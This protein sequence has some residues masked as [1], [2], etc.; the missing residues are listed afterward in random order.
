M[1]STSP[2]HVTTMPLRR[3]DTS[4]ERSRRFLRRLVTI[5]ALLNGCVFALAA[6]ALYQSRLRYEERATAAASNVA[7][8]QERDLQSTVDQVNLALLTIADEVQETEAS[9]GRDQDSLEAFIVRQSTRLPALHGLRITNAGG[10]V[11]HGYGLAKGVHANLSDRAYFRELSR[12]PQAGIVISKPLVSRVS[13]E[14]EIV[15]ARRLSRPDGQ[16]D[17]VVYGTIPLK[18]FMDK[19]AAIDLGV[20]GV[21]ALR[22]ADLGMVVR[23]PPIRT[24]AQDV[25]S[26]AIAPKLR[27]SIETGQASGNFTGQAG[28]D[29]VQRA[30]AFRRIGQL[31][32]IIV[33]GL[34]KDDYLADWRAEVS[35]ALALCG[36][37]AGVV[38][39]FSALLHRSWVSRET[40]VNALELQ[41]R[42][43]RTLLESSPD[44]LVIADLQG[45]IA[46][47]NRNA[48]LM[49]GHAAEQ[50][51]GHPIHLLL[52]ARFADFSLVPDV[53]HGEAPEGRHELWAVTS[54][55]RE[56]PVSIS[57]SSINTDQ[58]G[59]VAAAI[60]DMTEHHASA[61]HIEY[62]A[63]HDALTG[64][65]NRATMKPRFAQASADAARSGTH[66]A[67][68]FLDLDGFKTIN[69]SL[70]HGVGDALLKGVAAR[71]AAFVRASDFV[72]RQGGDEFLIMLTGLAGATDIATAAERLM[73]E[74]SS[75]FF[76]DGQEI[77]TSFSV[78]VA[79]HPQ[80]GDDI[81]TILKKADI[82]MY[83]AKAAGRATWRLFSDQMDLAALARHRVRN[84]L[85][86]ALERRE[87][88]LHFQ[89]QIDLADGRFTGAEA[90]LRW[91]HAELGS[92][93]PATFIPVA[94]ESGLIVPIGEWVI[95]EACRQAVAWQSAGHGPL[96][97]AVNVSAVQ[98]GRGD[99]EATVRSA[100]DASGLAPQLLELEITESILIRNVDSVLATVSRLKRLGVTLSID[101]FGTGYSSLTY[102]KQ[103]AVDK[104]KIDQS[105]I[106]DL[107]TSADSAAIVRAVVE[108]ARSLGL[109]TVAEGIED[110]RLIADLHAI[111]CHQGQGYGIARPMPEAAFHELLRDRAGQ[112]AGVVLE[113]L[114]AHGR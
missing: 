112:R 50:M 56:F 51:V 15:L 38:L 69:D 98:F 17:G 80:D 41:E 29:G 64:L 95:H 39:L 5:A 97:V 37:F 46:L 40:D 103:L 86:H 13:G 90:L 31:P 71:L 66:V 12:N 14:W 89:P 18:Y 10:D 65:P 102:L 20:H 30:L 9:P 75:P 79:V 72:S 70:G 105:F 68:L 49:F 52:P 101:D 114:G 107:P 11:I 113:A 3:A 74:F 93:T 55:G 91:T 1:A 82:A 42:K 21:I 6:M 108:M 57:V 109:G 26:Q 94:E 33:V 44:A 19:F 92:V 47:V 7:V 48:E 4:A 54:Q 110:P 53:V 106:R 45:R 28:T 58:G 23:W 67:L 34:G 81:E 88:A 22:D 83:Q 24:M 104:L 60:R 2:E 76:I 63:H 62:L 111:G 59:V 100:L 16:F 8:F 84:A 87:F 85:H 36:V 99:L 35:R 73:R 27:A 96:S 32:L 61:S 43:F 78:G 77:A 25:G